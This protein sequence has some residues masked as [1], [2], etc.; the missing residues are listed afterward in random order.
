MDKILKILTPLLVT[1]MLISCQ[2]QPDEILY[3]T[4]PMTPDGGVY[5]MPC[6]INGL[7]LKF[8]FDTGAS[9]VSISLTEASF[10][11]KNDF[12]SI[13]QYKMYNAYM[14]IQIHFI[15]IILFNLVHLNGI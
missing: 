13:K 6:T 9:D 3:S 11:L 14:S 7:P 10:M 8:I 5:K 2:N 1:S 4:I 12:I 15:N